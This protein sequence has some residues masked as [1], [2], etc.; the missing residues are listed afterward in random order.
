MEDNKPKII[1]KS[2]LRIYLGIVIAIFI[3]IFLRLAW[4]QLIEADI[5]QTKAESNTMRWIPEVA[6]RGEIVDNKG[7]VLVTNRPV[8]TVSLNYLGLKDQDIDEVIK[9]L[10]II[11]NDSEIT[12]NSIEKIITA[13]RSRLF[14]PIVIKR[15]V[16]MEIVTAIEERR[17]VLPGVSVDVYPQRSYNY[18]ALAGHLLGY[19][20]SIKEELEK[21]GFEDYGMTDL[22]GKTGIEKNYEQYLRGKNGF[23]QM[24][25]TSKN[26]PVR[27]IR[28]IPSVQGDKLVITIDLKLQQVMEQSF[29]EA[30]VEVQKKH[31]K[32]MAGAAV[33]LDVNTGKVLAM[34]SRPTLNPDDFNGKHLTQEKVDYYFRN[35]PPALYNRAV[36]GS[37]VPGSIFK[38]ITGM[39]ALESGEMI[40]EDNVLCNGKYW[41]PPYIKCWSVHGNVNYYSAMAKSCNVYF[42]E[43]ARRAG[44]V[45]I[46]RVGQDFGLGEITGIDIPY[47]SVGTLPDLEWQKNKFEDRAKG[48]NEKIDKKIVALEEEYSKKIAVVTTDEEKKQLELQLKNEKKVWEQERKNQLAHYTTWHDWDT[49]NTG[50]GQGYNEYTIIQLA[51]YVATLANGGERYKPYI[52][53]KI[54]DANGNIIEEYKPELIKLVN[55]APEN[56]KKTRDAMLAVTAPGGTA[57]SIFRNFPEKIKVGAKT[58]T[59]QPGR[60]GYIKNKDY[61]GLFIAFA[62]GDDPQIAFAGVMEHGFSGGG[63]VGRVAK[64]VFE[65]YFKIQ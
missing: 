51:N 27:E 64:A 50:I 4:L 61:D 13:Q 10:V 26:Q 47:E 23:R 35:I 22:V 6:S 17:R 5:Y 48:I 43:M 38:P 57:Y 30:M 7:Q 56:L 60:V 24:E 62:P 25:V 1:L 65:E 19:V 31:P 45:E 54:I 11:L 12:Y 63:S 52:V 8:F 46:G 34:V 15:D 42:Q 28:A 14:E 58:G 39:A 33:L 2:T 55:I 59:A 29:D 41:N 3:V 40:L 44:I 18:G 53:E 16:S 32:A 20:H 21:P 36:Q 9:K 37:Y 49:Y